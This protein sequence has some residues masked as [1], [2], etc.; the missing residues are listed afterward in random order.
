MPHLR[1]A[2]AA[3]GLLL[4]L[5]VLAS[6]GF[7]YPTERVNTVGAGITDRDGIVDVGGARIVA[8]QDDSG[9]FIGALTNNSTEDAISLTELTG[10]EDGEVRADAFDPVEIPAEGHLNLADL[11]E[12]DQGLTVSGDFA[13]GDFVEVTLGFDNGESVTMEIPVMKPCD[14]HEG[15]DNTQEEASTEPLYSCEAESDAPAEH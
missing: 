13:A 7:D 1:S 8:G 2:L 12:N 11:A 5:P 10:G 4:A 15:L 14:Q 9:T 6:C 3:G